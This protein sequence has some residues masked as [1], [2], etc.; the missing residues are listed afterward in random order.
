LP[1]HSS[2]CV[3]EVISFR[4]EPASVTRYCWFFRLFCAICLMPSNRHTLTSRAACVIIVS[5]LV[6]LVR[7]RRH[8]HCYL[9]LL[10]LGQDAAPMDSRCGCFQ[11]GRLEIFWNASA[12]VHSDYSEFC[13]CLRLPAATGSLGYH[14]V[15]APDALFTLF[16]LL[17]T[18]VWLSLFSGGWGA[19]ARW[20]GGAAS[21]QQGYSLVVCASTP[22]RL[23][24][25]RVRLQWCSKKSF[26]VP[27]PRPS[28]LFVCACCLNQ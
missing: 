9:L 6:L 8:A 18:S 1:K 17:Q 23:C 28:F 5:C 27:T 14:S 15:R 21:R 24:T 13:Q 16:T 20:R 3:N 7:T 19:G 11:S 25:A 10:R 4:H 2:V 26:K 12:A 22:K